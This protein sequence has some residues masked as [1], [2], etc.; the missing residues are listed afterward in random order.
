MD[1]FT[2]VL[3]CAVAF[4]IWLLILSLPRESHAEAPD[5]VIVAELIET[6]LEG[7]PD[8]AAIIATIQCESAGN[9]LAVGDHGQSLGLVQIHTPSWP[10]I[11]R[12]QAFD[13]AFA[14]DFIIEQFRLGH[15]HYWTCWRHLAAL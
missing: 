6:K 4:F 3:L 9:P 11:S 12:A 8:R 5:K 14:M 2:K 1:N 13:P 7:N 10:G 15:A